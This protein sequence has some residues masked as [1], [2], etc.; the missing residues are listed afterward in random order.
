MSEEATVPTPSATTP[1]KP[2]ASPSVAPTGETVAPLVIATGAFISHEHRTSGEVKVL[3]LADGGWVLRL[4][5][6][7]TSNGPD[8]HVWL[9]E[10]PVLEGRDGWFV[11]DDAEH[12][13]LGELKGNQGN[14]NY[15]VPPG[16]DLDRLSPQREHRCQRFHVSFG[17][18]R[19][20]PPDGGRV[21][22]AP[23]TVWPEGSP[24]RGL[25]S[26]RGR[27]AS[28]TAGGVALRTQVVDGPVSLACEAT[29]DRPGLGSTGART[30]T[31]RRRRRDVGRRPRPREAAGGGRPGHRRQP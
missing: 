13:D 26:S 29:S 8:L 6:L 27:L 19:W 9:A 5:G 30:R 22:T 21:S 2:A 16:V 15:L 12:V 7:D 4:E 23:T 20:P 10:A 3:K 31:I 18:A 28:P 25:G 24:R 14:Q 11:F 17:A 1:G